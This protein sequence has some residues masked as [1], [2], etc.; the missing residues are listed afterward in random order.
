MAREQRQG[1]ASAFFFRVLFLF[2]SPSPPSPFLRLV[3]VGR[4]VA[5]ASS[6]ERCVRVNGAGTDPLPHTER[7]RSSRGN[8]DARPP[9]FFPPRA[10]QN[11]NPNTP[12]KTHENL[13]K[14]KN[15]Q[16]RARH[17]LQRLPD[18]R[19]HPYRPGRRLAREVRRPL[20]RGPARRAEK[21]GARPRRPRRL[22]AHR[23]RPQRPRARRLARFP[24]G[25]GR[26]LKSVP[27][28]F[29]GIGAGRGRRGDDARAGG[30]RRRDFGSGRRA[31]ARI[32]FGAQ[33]ALARHHVLVRPCDRGDVHVRRVRRAL[34]RARAVRLGRARLAAAL[35]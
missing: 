33:P 26:R 28:L 31:R 35:S 11:Q 1:R 4:P 25:H 2:P 6:P 13:R 32:C 21:S 16:P 30:K 14:T 29:E 27:V 17:H 34:L 7:A 23:A 5:I 9:P 12:T 8:D 3:S 18:L 15:K 24:R 10:H 22:L 20:S 19:R